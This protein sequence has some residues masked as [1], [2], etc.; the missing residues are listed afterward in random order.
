[1][2]FGSSSNT[3]ELSLE[4]LEETLNS[5][6]N[7]KLNTLESKASRIV[8][9]LSSIKIQFIEACD[10][11]EKLDIEP[12]NE[13]IYIDTTSFV[14][15][16]K[17][18]YAKTLKSLIKEWNLSGNEAPN[19][20]DNYNL[21][22]ANTEKSINEIL[23]AN[24]RFK[25]VLYSYADHL[26]YFKKHFSMIERYRD[27]LKSEIEKVGNERLEYNSINS[28]ITKLNSLI[29]E[30]HFVDK[31]IISLNETVKFNSGVEN[32]NEGRNT[33][34]TSGKGKR[35]FKLY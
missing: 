27:S 21:V 14:K 7:R 12:E 34:Q 28:Q 22:L 17:G 6:F 25:K 11:F 31:N 23:Q 10:K 8:N 5:S 19:I 9:D 3:E 2:L 24:N 32:S 16:Q 30:F 18:F 1:M 33:W 15:S 35:I 4:K 20:Y 29:E 26:D 13:N